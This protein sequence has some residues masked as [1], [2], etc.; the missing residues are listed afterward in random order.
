MGLVL[1]VVSALTAVSGAAGLAVPA[2]FG[3]VG[4]MAAI[5]LGGDGI[6]AAF[7]G[8][9]PTLDGLKSAVSASFE[10]SLTP[11]VNNLK[12]VLP[13]LK[14]GLQSIATAIGG[15]ATKFTAMLKNTTAA[16]QLNT[17]FVQFS[18]VIQNLGAFLAPVGQAF[19]TIGAVAAPMLAQLTTGLGAAGEQFNAF[20]QAA[21]ADGSLAAWIQR[22]IDAFSGLFA[23]L[24]QLGS[25][26]SSVFAAADAA[27][28]GF[29]G[30]IG[31]LVG[32]VA[33]F[34]NSFEGQT[35][36]LAFFEAVRMIGE[37]VG[38]VLAAALTAVAPVIPPLAAAFGTLAGQVAAVLVPAIQILGPILQGLAAFFAAN[39]AWIG[40]LA[41]AIGGIALAIQAVTLA[42]NLWKAAVA[43]YTVV[44]WLLNAAMSAN[45]IGLVIAAIVAIIAIIA[46]VI[47]N[48]DFFRGI[49]DAV[50]KWCSDL[51]TSIVD[52][53]VQKWEQFK[54]GFQIIVAAVK[55]AW[56]NVVNGIK[57]VVG[58]VVDWI[59]DKWNGF[60]STIKNV[61]SGIGSF[62]GGVWDG[63]KSGFKNAINGVIGF[64]NGA[65]G[66]I[67]TVTGAVG[68]PA[69]PKIPMLAKGG[70]AIG[71]RS[72]LVGEKGPELF[73]PGS[74]GRVT[75]ADTTAEAIG[76]SSAPPIIHVYIGDTELTDIVDIRIEENTLEAARSIRAG[77]GS[78]R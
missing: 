3:L 62:I 48:L 53:I 25:I 40:P 52:W 22:A 37:A 7:A 68:I 71:G 59:V 6:K 58:T 55:Q 46:L 66:A 45:P 76:A 67:N 4:V 14:T 8:L 19:I 72:Y 31:T 34:L 13:Q 11:A 24:G 44:Q 41:I 56:D 70:T 12:T 77:A 36:L 15:A 26:I 1:A 64:A 61:F 51:I 33:N 38:G 16:S 65:I 2:L 5:K 73:T 75:N 43:A 74:T 28:L 18:K 42:V 10:K 47:S 23:F 32:V 63:I 35:A 49:W 20:V 69:I 60:S 29:G 78:F 39:M 30:T 54:L 50:W 57:N 21:A 17:I 9:T 27:G